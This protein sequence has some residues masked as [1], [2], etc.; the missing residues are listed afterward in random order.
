[1]Q[2][3]KTL[4]K[5]IEGGS[6]TIPTRFCPEWTD[7]QF[8]GRNV[9]YLFERVEPQNAAKIDFQLKIFFTLIRA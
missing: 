4:K 1:M 8:E 2:L 9:Y 7:L 5:E 6:G 3:L